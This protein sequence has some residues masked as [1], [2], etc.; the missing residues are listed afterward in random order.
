M[1]FWRQE[2]GPGRWVAFTNSEAG[3]L[4]L[5]VGDQPASVLRRRRRLEAAMGVNE[6]SLRFMHQTHSAT[7]EI[8][9][10]AVPGELI[11]A[12]ALISV[13]GATPLAVMVADCVPVILSAGGGA[14]A[15]A[16]VHA[17]RQGTL[18]GVIAATVELLRSRQAQDLLAWIGPAVCGDCYEVPEAMR[19]EVAAV[20]PAASATTRWGT[21]GLDLPRAVRA[22]LEALGVAVRQVSADSSTLCTLENGALYSHRRSPAAGRMAGLVWTQ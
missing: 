22:Q 20:V 12:D 16:V 18:D 17:G 21:P 4:A 3:N 1:F 15:T 11:S 14:G 8:V 19:R 13:R 6:G 9:E 10:D 7:A 5:H 2:I